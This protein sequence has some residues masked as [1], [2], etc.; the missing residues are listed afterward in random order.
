MKNNLRPALRVGDV[1]ESKAGRGSGRIFLVVEKV[2]GEYVRI[3]DGDTRKISRAKLKK[4]LHLN[5]L[6]RVG[7]TAFLT[8]PGGAAD[9]EIRNIIKNKTYEEV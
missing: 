7:D 5:L 4:N 2:D 6:G 8:A 3:S 1:V 9:S